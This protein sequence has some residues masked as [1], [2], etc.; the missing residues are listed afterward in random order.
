MKTTALATALCLG[1]L[2]AVSPAQ[3]DPEGCRRAI[4]K[5]SALYAQQRLKAL[6]RCGDK[7]TAGKLP[8]GTDCGVE[9][10]TAIK[11]AKVAAKMRA[12]IDKACGGADKTCGAGGDDEPLASIGWDL[13][14][15]PDLLGQG[16]DGVLSDCGDVSDCLACLGDEASTDLT[17]LY[18]ADLDL[19]S[20]AKSPLE[21]C[22]RLIGKAGAKFVKL[23]SK[24]LQKCWDRVISGSQTGPCPTNTTQIL[25]D[26]ASEKLIDTICR[27]CG[28]IDRGCDGTVGSVPGTGGADDTLVADIGFTAQCRD[29]AIPGGGSCDAPVSTLTE[30][31]SCVH[32]VT[33][34]ATE[35]LDRAAVPLNTSYP[36]ECNGSAPPSCGGTVHEESFGGGNGDPWPPGWVDVGPDAPPSSS[37]AVADIQGGRARLQPVPRTYSLARMVGPQ[38][39]SDVEVLVTMEFEDLATQGIGF[40]VR[41]NGGYLAETTPTGE[42]YAVFVEGFRGFEGIGV[43]REVN[44]SEQSILIDTGLSLTDGV[45]YRVR[46][47]VHQQDASTTRLQ[48]RIWPVADPEPFGWNVDTTDSTP[49][50]QNVAGAMAVDSWSEIQTPNPIAAHTF[51]DDIVVNEICNPVFGIGGVTTISEA[52]QFT[53]GPRWRADGTLLFSDITADTIH[54]LTPPSTVGV[55]RTPSDEA[56]GLE[57]DTNGDLLAAEH[58]SRRI[59]RTDGGGVVTTVVDNYLGDAFNSPNDLEVRSDGTLYFTDPHYGLANPGDREIPFNGLYRRTPA[60]VLTA[61]WMGGTTEGPNGV[62]LSP[63]ETRLYMSKSDSGDVFVW[64][65]APDGSLGNQ[66]TFVSGLNIP[67]GMCVDAAGNLYV[68]T[69]SS[70]VEVYDPSGGAWATLSVPRQATNCTFGGASGQTLYVTA[71]EGLYSYT[72]P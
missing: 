20:P 51:V 45:P 68:A 39:P 14:T 15:C 56:N 29:V 6:A 62:V 53:E 22:Q 57:N 58:A 36:A 5:A 27:S 43:W 41:Q 32:C 10:K 4:A 9:A 38:A 66:R 7:V 26:K 21:K 8:P 35:C 18:F 17:A 2:S 48:A 37:V 65:V 3:A 54:R 1:L 61:E 44:G 67:D 23:K 25:L 71:H 46:F 52:F 60:G 11:L 64:D 42:G 13:G 49:S 33:D 12:T 50:I 34:F 40:Y 31:V 28:G 16:C 69:W 72:L 19:A 59:S 55:F 63:D 24:H 70:T 30:L 47:R